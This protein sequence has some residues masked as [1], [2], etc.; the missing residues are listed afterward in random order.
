MATNITASKKTSNAR[1][2][3]KEVAT[4]SKTRAAAVVA[5]VAAKASARPKLTA[6][7][8]REFREMLLE[9]RERLAEQISKLQEESLRRYDSVNSEEDGTDAYDRQFALTLAA[10]E[11]DSVVAIDDALLRLEEGTYGVCDACNCPIEKPRL[12]AL[13]FV[14]MCIK[15]KSEAER[16]RKGLRRG[17]AFRP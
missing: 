1:K 17:P 13:P 9:M 10:T 12:E 5:P 6:K 7:N 15:C 11:Q 4:S 2:S 3:T 14:R 16:S 8:K